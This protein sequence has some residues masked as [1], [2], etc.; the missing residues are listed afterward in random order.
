MINNMHISD[1]YANR[2]AIV[3][4]GY[5]RLDTIQR[6]LT[7]ISSA[8]YPSFRIPLV[9]SIDAGG[10][11]QLVDYVHNYE[12]SFGDKY[13][14]IHQQ[15]LGLRKH[16]IQCGDLSEHFSGII[17]LEDDV[18]VGPYYYQYATDALSYYDN[19]DRIGGVSLYRNEING[20]FHNLPYI[21]EQDGNDVFL[22]QTPASWG[23]CWSRRMWKQ[24]KSW[25]GADEDKD[26][27]EI[28]MPSRI[29]NWKKA[30]S[31]FFMAYLIDTNR[32]F[33]FPFISQ[34]TCFCDPGEHGNDVNNVGQVN[35]MTNDRT[36]VFKPFEVLTKYDIYGCNERLYEYLGIDK[37]K[38]CLNLYGNNDNMNNKQFMLSLM[39]YPYKVC[40]SYALQMRPVELNIKYNL[41][42][43]GVYL[44]DTTVPASNKASIRAIYNYYFRSVDL[45][46][47]KEYIREHYIGRVVSVFKKK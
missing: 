13:V 33:V 1:E 23:E 7:S 27:S 46:I 43:E 28:D 40:K 10:N 45:S 9:I 12:W 20:L 4:V 42:G 11:Q 24:F 16:I 30:W 41:S 25:L 47:I 35:L 29:K 26:I 32:Y 37:E 19:E 22:F 15:R 38:V 6:L 36:F 31:K 34:T 18:F 2:L 5:N 8:H 14:I 21:F 39:H 3:V 44:Y 17:L